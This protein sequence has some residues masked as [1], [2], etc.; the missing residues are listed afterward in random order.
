MHSLV[1]HNGQ[2]WVQIAKEMSITPRTGRQVRNRFLYLKGGDE[3]DG[4]SFTARRDSF[5]GITLNP[6]A[7][8][9]DQSPETAAAVDETAA[10]AVLKKNHNKLNSPGGDVDNG[11]ASNVH[12]LPQPPI[13]RRILLAGGQGGT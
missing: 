1:L 10:A 12:L 9:F 13:P 4:E 5:T 3:K 7:D 11:S 8:Q 2:R 6:N